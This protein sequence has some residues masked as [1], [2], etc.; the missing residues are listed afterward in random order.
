VIWT[1]GLMG[2]LGLDFTMG[3]V[4]GLPLILGAAGEFGLNIVLSAMESGQPQSALIAQNTLGAVLMNGLTTIAGF[5][6][7]L[8]ASH[9]GIFGL[10]LLLTLG[11]VTTLMASLIV[12]PT[13]LVIVARRSEPERV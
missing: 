8:V 6:S 12:L 13:L 1:V 9:R 4:F 7:L 11:T 5:A 10:G 2:F 3:N